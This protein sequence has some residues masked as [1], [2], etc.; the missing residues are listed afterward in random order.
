MGI[1]IKDINNKVAEDELLAATIKQQ[2]VE[3]TEVEDETATFSIKDI[4]KESS[5]TE[6]EGKC[7]GKVE[8]EEISMDLTASQ[9]MKI[10]KQIRKEMHRPDE[11]GRSDDIEYVTNLAF[12]Y[13]ED[14]PGLEDES[15][16]ENAV[17]KI[18][19]AYKGL[20]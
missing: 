13:A 16:A 5:V 10:A 4:A 17:K 19:V 11:D 6:A 15:A 9:A 8:D 18:V 3:E 14:I 7:G 12:Q 1:S 20:K 2:E